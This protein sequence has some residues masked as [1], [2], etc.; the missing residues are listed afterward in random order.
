MVT[1]RTLLAAAAGLWILPTPTL[2]AQGSLVPVDLSTW[3]A[4]DYPAVSGFGAGTWEV[5]D[6]NE[7]VLQTVNG[8][9]TFFYSDF[10]TFQNTSEGVIRVAGGSDDDYV[11]FAIGFQPGDTTNPEAEYLLIDWKR[12]TQSFN[13]GAP[14]ATPGSQAKRGL[15]VSRVFGIPTADELW[16]HV[17]F[18]HESS[19]IDSGLEELARAATL[20]DTGWER[21]RDYLF[22]FEYDSRSLKV[23]VDGLPEIDISGQFEDGRLAFY[24]FSQASVR[25]SGF[26]R[27]FRIT[28]IRQDE[29]G[30]VEIT[31]S[32]FQGAE[33]VVWAAS[34]LSGSDWVEA[35]STP[36]QGTSTSWT[37]PTPATGTR[38]YRIE[39]VPA[40]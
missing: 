10:L 11:G 15:A 6:G 33:Y 26:E 3:T 13:F 24:N 5:A 28:D 32:S 14:S 23:Y 31:W 8:Q 9:P 18:D 16:G 4:E 36:S 17:N 7:E 1:G 27:P 40:P 25:Y 12:G 34:D 20:G 39:Q 38:F 35:G 30:L 21:N 37:D 19:G 22:T 2:N 29:D